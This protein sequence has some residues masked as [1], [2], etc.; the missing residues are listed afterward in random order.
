MQLIK[1]YTNYTLYKY[2][3]N[4]YLIEAK[5]KVDLGMLFLRVQET[6]ENP[7]YKN[8]HF[9]L[10]EFIYSYQKENKDVFS[11]CKDFGGYNITSRLIEM[12]YVTDFH[13]NMFDLEMIDVYTNIRYKQE[14][15]FYLIGAMKGDRIT[16]NHELHHAFFNNDILYRKNMLSLV[17]ELKIVF[18]IKYRSIIKILKSWSYDGSVIKDE[19]AAYISTDSHNRWKIDLNLR[20]KFKQEFNNKYI[21]TNG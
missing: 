21:Q 16:L 17:K 6:M 20:K 3:D 10:L 4:I 7:K 14:G 19:I 12:V 8:K 1:E 5:S 2:I 13:K 11:Y 9:D 18:P 15:P